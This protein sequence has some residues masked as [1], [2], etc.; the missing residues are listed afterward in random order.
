MAKTKPVLKIRRSERVLSSPPK[1][2]SQ[3]WIDYQ[4]PQG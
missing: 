2:M 3:E 4:V 1:G